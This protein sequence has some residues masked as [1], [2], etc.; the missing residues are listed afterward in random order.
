MGNTKSNATFEYNFDNVL[1]LTEFNDIISDKTKIK[2]FHERMMKVGK[3]YIFICEVETD[4][5]RMDPDYMENVMIDDICGN[6]CNQ[7]Y[8]AQ[9]KTKQIAHP[10]SIA[11]IIWMPMIYH[12]FW[13]YAF[14]ICKFDRND[15]TYK[16]LVIDNFHICDYF[17][18]SNYY[19]QN[20]L[21]QIN[22]MFK[23]LNRDMI[24]NKVISRYENNKTKRERENNG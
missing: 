6:Y 19:M 8:V 1:S 7:Y 17:T 15:T 4:E 23:N 2:M 16:K 10:E 11:D 24:E 22:D 18:R 12:E 3:C 14:D 20:D 21:F 13:A 5:D 9:L